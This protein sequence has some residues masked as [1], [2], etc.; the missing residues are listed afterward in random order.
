MDEWRH[1]RLGDIAQDVT[2]GHV[3]TMASQYRDDGIPFLRS[4]N[5]DRF[6][7]D[8]RDVKYINANFH[9]RLRKSELRPDDVV[10]V[11]TGK[12]GTTA[13][14]P[15]GLGP[16]NCSDMVITRPGPSLDSRWLSYYINGA[17]AG[18]IESQLVGAVQQHFNVG[19]AKAM[20]L[21][22]PPITQQRAIAEVLG[23]IDDK[24]AA[25]SATVQSCRDL[26]SLLGSRAAHT[27]TLSEIVRVSKIS[28]APEDMV[29]E[30]VWHYSLPAFDQ[31]EQPSLDT[32]IGIKS[33][34]FVINK[35]CVLISKLNPRF[36]RVWN[37][38]MLH[39]GESVASTEFVVLEPA[40]C[41]TG[42]LW[43]LL[44]QRSFGL[45]LE[46]KVSGTSGSHQR[47]RP[48]DLLATEVGDPRSVPEAVQAQVTGLCDLV[49]QLG[50]ESTHLAD[51]RDALLPEVM[52]GRLRVRDAEKQVEDVV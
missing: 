47:V 3:G 44:G 52:S 22:L 32:T 23:A 13:V 31:D 38:P 26:A 36:P 12:P 1:V 9:Q 48:A 6:R 17:A 15:V 41:S 39:L 37:V 42:M 34:K 14:I 35:P 29:T 21:H 16:A 5:I 50:Q 40:I 27:V 51:V 10:T 45:V 18:F 33:A 8:L 30:S 46:G 20:L 24:I 49:Y 28:R 4:Q 25:N 11:R 2:V 19:S 7:L 43:A